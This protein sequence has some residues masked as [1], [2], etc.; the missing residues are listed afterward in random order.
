MS[1]NKELAF[2]YMDFLEKG[3][4]KDLLKLFAEN[5]IVDSP[6]YGKMDVAKFYNELNDD[7]INSKL[8]LTTIFEEKNSNKIAIHFIY[9]YAMK[10]KKQVQFDV[11]DI[12]EFNE[13]SQINKLKIIYD[14][15]K[16]RKM[17]NDL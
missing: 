1:T 11:V 6:V 13:F 9:N 14:T 3:N 15:A 5:G 8:N 4:K 2:K 7:T 17:D 12:L 16:S 10:N